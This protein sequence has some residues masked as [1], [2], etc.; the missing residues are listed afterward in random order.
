MR[1]NR[2]CNSYVATVGF[3]DGIHRGHTHLIDILKGLAKER[4]RSSMVI[5]FPEHPRQA[6]QADYSPCLLTTPEDKLL[7][8]SSLEVDSCLP[9]HFTKELSQ[10]NAETFM[11]TFLQDKLGVCTLL[12]GYDHHFGCDKDGSI[13]KYMDIGRSI[14]ME[15]VG[16]DALLYKQTA[17]SSSR[18]RRKL[19]SG[20]IHDAN[21]MLGY[22]YYI[23]G[24]VVHGRQNGRQIGFPTANLELH[25]SMIHIPRNGVYASIV[26][27]EG[28][29]YPAMVN[30]GFRP[31][32]NG[33]KERSI[34]AHLLGFSQDIYS[35]SISI[36]FIEYIRSETKFSSTAELARQLS[37]DKER[38]I[39]IINKQT[40]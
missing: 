24:S 38:V 20:E 12:V 9:I 39:Q 34:E 16:A 7:R 17:I 36:Q 29:E 19:S 6:L 23:V 13:G 26:T 32:F 14:G 15:V 31:T 2:K 30:I 10:L 35:Q 8:I 27:V 22:N 37:L 33:E 18:I 28:V 21:N 40:V 5:T 11:K 3:F 1:I 25:N 4:G